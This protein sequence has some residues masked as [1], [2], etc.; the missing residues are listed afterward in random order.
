LKLKKTTIENHH[1][2][3]MLWI[4]QPCPEVVR[5]RK[6]EKAG[7]FWVG[8]EAERW[9]ALKRKDREATSCDPFFLHHHHSSHTPTFSLALS[10]LPTWAL[11]KYI[12]HSKHFLEHHP[13]HKSPHTEEEPRKRKKKKPWRDI[14]IPHI[15]MYGR[16]EKPR[17]LSL[18]TPGPPNFW[19]SP[20]QVNT[21][22]HLK[23]P[24]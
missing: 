20:N 15:S 12:L 21:Y 13:V 17:R 9:R 1:N 19:L 5:R 6:S 2:M 3:I 18:S 10:S 24:V 14:Q 7:F 23:I 22:T 8:C 16:K 4:R 11:S